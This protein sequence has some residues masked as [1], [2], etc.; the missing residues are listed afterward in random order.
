[1]SEILLKKSSRIDSVSEDRSINYSTE[2]IMPRI[3]VL[4]TYINVS[5]LKSIYRGES[6]REFEELLADY[7]NL[8]EESVV[9][10]DTP[11][12]LKVSVVSFNTT[13]NEN[14]K[15]IH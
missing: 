13:D 7:L 5:G 15:A 1:M 8:P 2:P 4:L 14:K 3:S 12:L 6:V 11:D 9:R 10:R